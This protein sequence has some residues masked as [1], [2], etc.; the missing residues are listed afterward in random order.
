MRNVKIPSRDVKHDGSES[1][2]VKASLDNVKRGLD[3]AK[4]DLTMPR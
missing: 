1:D 3:N 4:G 2:D